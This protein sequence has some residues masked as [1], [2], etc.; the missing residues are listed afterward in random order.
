MRIFLVTNFPAPYRVPLYDHLAQMPGIDLLVYYSKKGVDG[1]EWGV[2]KLQHHHRIFDEGRNSFSMAADFNPDRV[3]IAGFTQYS[4]P[5]FALK[6]NGKRKISIFT[7]M[8]DLPFNNLRAISRKVRKILYDRADHFI[9]P[10]VKSFQ[11][12]KKILGDNFPEERICVIPLTPD[13]AYF[14]FTSTL[15]GE[16]E[17]DLIFSGQII[18]RKL[19][20]F[21]TEVCVEVDSRR[22]SKILILGD[23]PLKPVMKEKLSRSNVD[24]TFAGYIP[25]GQ[26]QS[27]YK[28]GRLLLFP[29]ESD[30]WG[31]VANEALSA[32]IPVIVSP[33]AGAAG[34]L[35]IS[36]K[37][38]FVLENDAHLWAD[39]AI[40]IL[41]GKHQFTFD[42]PP[43]IDSIARNLID[44]LEALS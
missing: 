37:N 6:L 13:P 41:E 20:G 14:P 22:K 5:L 8:W 36:G 19:P 3:I 4:L 31:I 24:H 2:P 32:S 1:H 40:E 10:G 33:N 43:T 11:H 35:V 28:K 12:V 9:V 44:S 15:P 27:Y 26:L 7:D 23:G 42:P 38:G 30:P 29:T 18:D 16:K 34:D 39:R 21:F 25:Q 17:Y